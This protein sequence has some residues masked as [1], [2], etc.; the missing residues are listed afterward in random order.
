[1]ATLVE[2]GL[3]DTNILVYATNRDAQN[4]HAC[5]QLLERAVAREISAYLAPQILYE[6]FAVVTSARQLTTPLSIADAAADVERLRVTLPM[7]HATPATIGQ[8]M[9]LLRTLGRS[10]KQVFDLV[11]VA[12]M[13]EN[14]LSTIFTYD[15]Q[16][17]TVPGIVALKPEKV[18]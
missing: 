4:H 3:L 7:I 18:A 2:P 14:G 1:M 12:T 15:E 16:F 11:L 10:G 13:F 9:G 17:A 5:R 8:A 6:Y